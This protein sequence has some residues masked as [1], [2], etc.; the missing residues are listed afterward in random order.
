MSKRLKLGVLSTSRTLRSGKTVNADLSEKTSSFF[1]EEKRSTKTVAK[2]RSPI[3]IECETIGNKAND[4][5][6][7]K[8]S[9]VEIKTEN[10]EISTDIKDIKAEILDMKDTNA[11]QSST[12]STNVKNEQWVP[13]NWEIVLENIKEMRKHKTAP[14]DEMGCHKC[15][16]PD[17]SPVVF[18][19]QSLI[20]LML[21]SQTKDQVTHA[22]MQR[23][24]AHG[25]K[26]D[27]IAATPDDVLG[28]LIYPVGFWKV[29]INIYIR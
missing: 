21:S 13:P 5:S 18:R 3:K 23:L 11:K 16:D 9:A 26:P 28:K 15:S 17:S 12:D 7:N 1:V 10:P 20:S 22:A 19:Y 14:V 6:I 8:I 4:D 27:V 29:Q 25:C 2:K 24:N